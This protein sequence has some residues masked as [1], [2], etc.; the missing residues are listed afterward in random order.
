MEHLAIDLGGR[1]SQVCVRNPDGAIV[2]EKVVETKLLPEFLKTRPHSRVVLET[3]AEALKVADAALAAGHEVRVV[4]ATLV[5]Q[6]GVGS[7]SE[8]RSTRCP[9]AE[10]RV[11]QDRSAFGAHTQSERQRSPDA[12]GD[13][14]LA[15][16]GAHDVDQ[17]GQRVAAHRT[18][19]AGRRQRDVSAQGARCGARERGGLAV[20]R[21]SGPEGD[22]D[23]QP[24]DRAGRRRA[25]R[26]GS[27]GRG[28][29][30]LD[31]GAGRGPRHFDD[32]CGG[33]RR[34]R[35][36]PERQAPGVLHRSDARREVERGSACVVARP[37]RVEACVV[38]TH[39]RRSTRPRG[40]AAPTLAG[41][42]AGF[43]SRGDLAAT[44]ARACFENDPAQA[45][46]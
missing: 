19:A 21:R 17:L 34:R 9:G 13:A 15:R 37:Q 6:L 14:R 32:V 20:V 30:A 43:G 31:D 40:P 38:A 2:L 41:D 22:G 24:A 35:S 12:G 44:S 39:R 7:G 23:A 16:E 3:C 10:R 42:R 28:V 29:P 45:R 4:P 27:A 33:G 5:R 26:P 1:K 25:A 11:V 8:D 46:R 36:F 18:G